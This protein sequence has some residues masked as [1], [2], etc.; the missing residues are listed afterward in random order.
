[1]KRKLCVAINGALEIW[2]PTIVLANF[3]DGE[4]VQTSTRYWIATGYFGEID[5]VVFLD[6]PEHSDREVIEEDFDE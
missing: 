2:R 4:G 3:G 6:G 5:Q 1:M